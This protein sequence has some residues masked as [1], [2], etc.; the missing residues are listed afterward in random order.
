LTAC[1]L[2]PF[3]GVADA[4]LHL[5][6]PDESRDGDAHAQS[7][8]RLSGARMLPRRFVYISTSGV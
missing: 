3:A 5:A 7:D 1:P 6:P 8:R 4:V 2:A